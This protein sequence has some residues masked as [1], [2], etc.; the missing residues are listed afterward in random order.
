MYIFAPEVFE[1]KLWD[2]QLDWTKSLVFRPLGRLLFGFLVAVFLVLTWVGDQPVEAPF[3]WMGWGHYILLYVFSGFHP[4][5]GYI[6]KP[7]D[8]GLFIDQLTLWGIYGCAGWVVCVCVCLY[9][10]FWVWRVALWLFLPPMRYMACYGWWLLFC[11]GW[12]F[13]FLRDRLHCVYSFDYIRGGH[14][15]F[16]FICNYDA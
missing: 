8:E 3:T 4:L 7:Y 16:I 13:L 15:N 5:S 12:H 2:K 14:S 9:Y 1:L 6:G 10:R 11:V